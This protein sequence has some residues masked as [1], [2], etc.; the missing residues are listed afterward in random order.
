MLVLNTI[1]TPVIHALTRVPVKTFFL[2]DSPTPKTHSV[3][4][5]LDFLGPEWCKNVC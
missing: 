4:F 1:T 3:L 2:I 5:D